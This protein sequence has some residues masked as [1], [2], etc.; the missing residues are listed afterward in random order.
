M[1]DSFRE[2]ASPAIL[3]I[4]TRQ[5]NESESAVSRAFSAAI[6]A[7]GATIAN[8]SDDSGFMKELTDLA[9]RTAADPDPLKTITRLATSGGTGIDTTSPTGS[10]LSSLFGHNLSG[11]VDSISNY[12]GIRGSSAASILSACAPLVLG[13]LGR[14]MRSD[15]LTTAG[16]ADRLRAHRNQLASAVPLG[17]EMPEFFHTPYRAARAAADDSVRPVQA[18]EADTAWTVP[19]LA[20]IGLLGLSGLI[21]WASRKPVIETS[22]VEQTQPMTPYRAPLPA[23]PAPEREVGTTGMTP[24]TGTVPGRVTRTL[25]GNVI[26]TIPAGGAAD[27]LFNYVSTPQ[28]GGTVITLDMVKFTNGSAMLSPDS[29]EQVDNVATILKAYPKTDVT[30]AGYTDNQGN[31]HA[32]MALSKARAEAVAGRIVAKGVASDR[33]HSEGYGSEKAVGDNATDEGRAE[34]RRVTLEVR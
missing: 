1:L 15:N 32:N 4:L 34:N 13:Y 6:P 24:T 21:W 8:R 23:T 9:T 27:R 7:I 25:P 11:M 26:I 5:T 12:A 33:V 3:S 14:M 10:F 31:E 20:L 30:V 2:L 17:F 29:R 22:R 16:L 19:V 18:R 28:T